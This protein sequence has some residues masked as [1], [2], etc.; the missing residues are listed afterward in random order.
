MKRK[1]ILL[2]IVIFLWG[3]TTFGGPLRFVPQTFIQPNGDTLKCFASGDEF[4]HWLHD[5]DGYTITFNPG[6]KYWVYA[7]KKGDD[8]IPTDLIAGKSDPVKAKL[9]KWLLP[10]W[11]S[12]KDRYIKRSKKKAN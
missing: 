11:N 8:L 7:D 2:L 5:K 10:N 3:V 1:N 9:K 6:T 4:Y 12:I